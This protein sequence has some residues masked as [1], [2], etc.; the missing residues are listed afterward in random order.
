LPYKHFTFYVFPDFSLFVGGE[1]DNH[2]L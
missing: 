1:C 2:L